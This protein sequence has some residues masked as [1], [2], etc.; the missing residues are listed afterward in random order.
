MMDLRSGS[1]RH[2]CMIHVTAHTQLCMRTGTQSNKHLLSLFTFQYSCDFLS[3][4]SFPA[5]YN[6]RSIKAVRHSVA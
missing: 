1:I 3:S 4:D 6:G 2:P 5:V